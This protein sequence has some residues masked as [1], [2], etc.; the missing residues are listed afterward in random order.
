MLAA[1]PQQSFQPLNCYHTKME[2]IARLNETP[3]GR[4]AI[5]L[6]AAIVLAASPTIVVAQQTTL[7]GRVVIEGTSAPLGDA[8]VLILRTN[9]ATSTNADGR[10]T[11][12][13]VPAGSFEVRVIRVGYVEQEHL[14]TV[15][16]G[17]VVSLDFTM[18]AA[19]LN[20]APMVATATGDQ[21]KVELGNSVSTIDAVT[22]VEE[23]SVSSFADLLVAKSPGVIVGPPNMT[24]S[25]PVVRIRGVSS[26]S[27]SNAPMFVV[28]GVR[29][30]SGSMAAR[31][32]GTSFSF[33]NSLSPD[34]IESIEIVKGPS[35]GTLYGTDAANGVVIVTTKQGRAGNAKWNWFAETGRV[36]DRNNYPSTYALWGHNP[37]TSAT[38]RCQLAT[39]APQT[40][41][42]DSL[43]SLNIPMDKTIGPIGT[44]TNTNFGSQVSGG[45][46]AVRYF[47]SGAVFNEVG[48]YTMPAFAVASLQDALH[49][50]VRDEWLHPEAMQRETVRANVSANVTP[51]FDINVNLG[52]ANSDQRLPQTD[53][54]SLGLG[55]AMLGTFGTN[56]AGLP[57][58]NPVGKLEAL[59]GYRGATPAEIFQFTTTER[60]Q[61]TAGS[62]SAQW[63]PLT[64]MQ[65]SAAIGIDMADQLLLQLCRLGECTGNTATSRMGSVYDESDNSRS[66][67]GQV[68]STSLWNPRTSVSL[69]STVGGGY[70]NIETDATVASGT[71]LPP[72]AET[73]GAAATKNASNTPPTASKTLGFYFQEEAAIRDRLFLAAAVRSDQNSAFGASFQRVYY[74]QVSLSWIASQESF[75]RLPSAV[76]EFRIRGAYGQSGVQPN[77]TDA[78][79]T[80]SATTVNI[81]NVNTAGLLESAPGNPNLKP[82]T[83]AEFEGGFDLR[84]LGNRVDVDVAYYSK[85]TRDALVALPIA[86]SAAPSALSVRTNVGSIKNAG[87]EAQVTTQLL[88]A[89]QLG[90]T[91][92]ISGSHNTNKVVSLG[93][94]PTGVANKTIL[95]G[96]ATRDSVGLPVNGVF[97]RNY[98]FKDANGDGII[99]P[100]EVTVDTG[101]TYKGYSVPRDLV[102]IQS[103]VELLQRKVRVN[104]LLDYKGGYN[105][106]NNTM[107]FICGAPFTCAEDQDKSVSLARQARAVAQNNGTTINGTTYK[108]QFGYWENGQ[109]WRLRELSAT[110]ELPKSV[111]HG[112]LRANDCSVTFGA[113]NLHVWTKYLGADPEE[114]YSTS[115]V[116]IDFLTAPPRTYFTFRAN[117]HY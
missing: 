106:F 96:A 20:L 18:K 98:S 44:G 28:D 58:Y 46:D 17:A 57:D 41:V 39:M 83:S 110:W 34:E 92:T 26:L 10:Y 11:I 84:A 88:D 8:R 66:F 38:I 6:V 72:G 31:V 5:R 15:A 62:A 107:S 87:V 115:D 35:A 81:L 103:G 102:S 60:I 52:F 54:N 80:F 14:V 16:P 2:L 55:F 112:V 82:E 23:T 42:A 90:W 63:R 32:G 85:Q 24:G 61:R 79:R 1:R 25:A 13:N 94:D 109:F 111:A 30:L 47:M 40:C 78:L 69:K 97:V 71:V 64:W 59:H 68:V 99:Q 50:P 91:M 113:R 73:V 67:G 4:P 21:R 9:L 56:H 51:A 33:L 45:S 27:L 114:N 101:V 117:L 86:A 53:N 77:A 108:T 29:Y 116:P 48:P 7:R 22:R 36:E 104:V 95:I 43:T 65:N 74:P 93:V 37:A 19:A 3:G 70:G 75:V 49:T 89:R 12:S 105:L 76:N 100:T